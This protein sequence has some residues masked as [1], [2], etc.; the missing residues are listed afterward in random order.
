MTAFP[1]AAVFGWPAGHSRSPLVHG[2][3]LATHGLSGAYLRHALPPEA[4]AATLRR[5]PDLGLVGGNVTIPHKE[6]ALALADDAEPVARAIGAANTLW[7]EGGRLRATNTDAAGFLANLDQR[8]PGWD[9][10]RDVAL[11]LGAGGSA[12]AIVWALLDRGFDRVVVAN[13]TRAKAEA[14]A[15]TFGPR[16]VAADLAE[17]ARHASAASVAVNTT[18]LGMKGEGGLPLDVSALPE[19]A[20]VCDI[21]YVPLVTPFLAA[22]AARGLATVDGLGMLLHQAAPGFARWFGVVPNVTAELRALVVADLGL[23]S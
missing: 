2:Y 3:W 21:V 4:A 14:L 16:V 17:A 10:R 5:L 18:S 1:A 11:V 8:A 19:H 12:R 7:I 15:E 23:A 6:V 13:R 9:R 20:V 22:A